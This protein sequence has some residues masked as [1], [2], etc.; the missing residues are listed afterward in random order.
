MSANKKLVTGAL[1]ACL[2]LS[3]VGGG[4]WAA[5]NDVEAVE[6]HLAAGTLDLEVINIEGAEATFNVSDLKPGDSMY[7]AFLLDNVGS[8]A[9]KEVLLDVVPSGFTNGEENEYVAQTGQENNIEEFLE[10][11]NVEM[12]WVSSRSFTDKDPHFLQMLLNDPNFMIINSGDSISLKDLVA[13]DFPA[14]VKTGGDGRLNLA[15]DNMLFGQFDGLPVK[16]NDKEAILMKISMKDEESREIEGEARG[17][18]TQN[19]YQGD[20][21]DITF[22]LEATQWEGMNVQHN[23][24]NKQNEKAH[25]GNY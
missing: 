21:V 25:N 14:G 19:R 6:N 9:I 2:G 16:P 13:N 17:E 24:Y 11:F 15:P 10:Q 1:S 22:S 4:T 12:V 3:L 23:G 5:F 20:A 18:F 7:R 8:L